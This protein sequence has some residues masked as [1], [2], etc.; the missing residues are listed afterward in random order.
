MK[1]KELKQYAFIILGAIIFPLGV[2]Y[3]IAPVHIYNGG[4]IGVSQLIRTFIQPYLT[5]LIAPNMDIAGIINFILNIPLMVLAY[6]KISKKFFMKTILSI[7][8]QMVAFSLIP[9]PKQLILPDLLSSV[10]I[11]GLISG[12]GVGMTLRAGGSS[13]GT[14][15]I[16][17]Y[18]TL[19]K[20]GASVGK[21]TN[22]LN[23]IVYL[24]CA[25]MF[26]VATAI[27]SIIYAFVLAM[28]CDKYHHQN[29]KVSVTIVTRNKQ[30]YKAI[31]EK[32]T[33]GVT[34]WNGYGGYADQDTHILMTVISKYEVIEL[35]K[36]V[37]ELDPNAF[38]TMTE[39]LTIIGNFEKRLF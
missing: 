35:K 39:G 38:I 18:Y 2:N 3:F 16:G 24:F 22:A 7:G 27:Y 28:I 8:V 19:K 4:I 33:R 32:L 30:V 14:D 9:I 1:I 6:R 12:I 23:F 17:V 13:G 36:I 20:Q 15:I 26:N 10:V 34:Y 29:I 11:G 37:Y 31:C 25:V 21:L 5:G